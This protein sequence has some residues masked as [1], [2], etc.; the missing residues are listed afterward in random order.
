MPCIT[1]PPTTRSPAASAA[2]SAAV[3]AQYARSQGSEL[4][5]QIPG[6]VMGARDDG[7]GAA[8]RAVA[9]GDAGGGSGVP[10]QPRQGGEGRC[11][12]NGVYARS[13]AR[14]SAARCST[15][16]GSPAGAAGSIPGTRPKHT[17]RY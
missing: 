17:L 7:V 1:P 9:P 13:A 12:A 3:N 11:V 15:P 16:G 5:Q 10:D 4:D 6:Q 2:P 8:G 14:S